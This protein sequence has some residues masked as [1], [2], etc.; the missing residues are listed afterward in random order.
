MVAY[1]EQKQG[2]YAFPRVLPRDES[3]TISGG[4][5]TM[6]MLATVLLSCAL[7]GWANAYRRAYKDAGALREAL[8]RGEHVSIW[9][10]PKAATHPGS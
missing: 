6:P 1:E 8:A 10:T 5:V 4:D 3:L 7:F 2:C 9:K